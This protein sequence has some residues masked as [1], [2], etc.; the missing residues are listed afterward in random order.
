MKARYAST[1]LL[2]TIWSSSSL[3]QPGTLDVTFDSDG[4]VIDAPGD[5]HDVAY[6]VVAMPDNT[7]LVCGVA[8]RNGRNSIFISRRFEDGSLDT[9]FG[10]E[11]GY[12]FFTIGEEAYGYAMGIDSQGR[13][14]VCG[15]AYPDFSQSVVVLVRT[16]ASGL[17]DATFD[18]DGALELPIGTNDSEAKGLVVLP[19]D[20]VILAGSVVGDDFVRDA[21]FTRIT[22]GGALDTGFGTDGFTIASG[23]GGESLLNDATV[24]SDGSIVGVGYTDVNFVQKTIFIKSNADGQLSDNFGTNGILLPEIGTNDHSAWGVLAS[25]NAFLVTG[26]V[27]GT[28]ESDIYVTM[29]REDGLY[30]PAF[31]SGAPVLIDLND[32]E[33]GFDLA[34]ANGQIYVCGTTGEPG[35]GSPR[36]FFVAKMNG[37]GVLNAAF[38]SGGA[39]VTSIQTDFDDANA[40][41]IQPD[42]KLVAAGFTS[43]F[44]TGGDNEV[45]IVRYRDD[46]STVVPTRSSNAGGSVYPN[47]SSGDAVFVR[48]ALSGKL[49]VSILDASGREVRS[50]VRS[51]VVGIFSLPIADLT[52]GHYTVLVKGES[53]TERSIVVV[54]R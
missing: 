27:W 1:L 42:G 7:I 17:P 20:D 34:S 52:N 5:L 6:D 9:N 32:Y 53:V 12:T 36:D 38:G 2:A 10:A 39:T 8:Q 4:I 46:G 41:A 49:G 26:M 48:T 23:L 35:F 29:I 45:A 13:I 24:L 33:V 47:P 37:A 16:D 15:L 19:S 21:M 18:G 51:A 22:Q 11:Q 40:L 14:Y 28:S 50:V 43:G 54:S 25:G 30:N 3:A 31:G 44:S